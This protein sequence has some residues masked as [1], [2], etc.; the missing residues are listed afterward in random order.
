MVVCECWCV[1]E[2]NKKRPGW[3][4]VA[5][6]REVAPCPPRFASCAYVCEACRVP[7]V[8]CEAKGGMNILYNKTRRHQ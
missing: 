7:A 4:A 5:L 1:W 6:P 8:A 2:D 3:H